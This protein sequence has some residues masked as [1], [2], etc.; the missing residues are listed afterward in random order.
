MNGSKVTDFQVPAIK[1]VENIVFS[2]LTCN[3]DVMMTSLFSLLNTKYIYIFGVLVQSY[4]HKKF[5]LPSTSHL[6]IFGNVVFFHWL[7]MMTSLWRQYSIYG[8]KKMFLKSCYL[9]LST[10]KISAPSSNRSKVMNMLLFWYWLPIM[11]SWWCHCSIFKNKVYIFEKFMFNPVH[12]QNFS[13]LAL[14]VQKVWTS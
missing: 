4:L 11:T 2:A 8:N 6:K 1:K 14:T 9:I 12:M 5:Q 13:S 3:N 7:A 10:H